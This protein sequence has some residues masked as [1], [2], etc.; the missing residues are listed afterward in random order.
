MKRTALL[1]TAAAVAL[2]T[3]GCSDSGSGGGKHGG[4]FTTIDGN[5]PIDVSAPI[6]PYNQSSNAY[7]GYDAMQLAWQKNSLTDPN[8]FYPGIAKSWQIAEDQSKIT[9]EL[10]PKAKWS[11]GTDVTADDIK[12]SAAVAFTQ[13]S[14]A[15]QVSPGAAGGLGEV[16]VLGSKKVEFDQAPGAKNNTF[17]KNV[18]TLYVLPKSVYSS[19][20]PANFWDQLKTAID[21]NA[22]DAAAQKAAQ[23]AITAL[24]KKLV[25]FG[26]K[27]DISCGPFVL[28]RLN[29]SEALLVKNKYYFNADKIGPDK[30]ISKN[31]S[32]NEQIWNYLIAGKLDMA[33]YT[34]TPTNVVQK[35]LSK[36]GNK[37]IT[38]VSQVVASLAF[39]QS[40]HPF[41]NVHVRRGLAYLID[42]KQVTKVGE[43]ESGAASVTTS[44]LHAKVASSVLGD[45]FA[46]LNKYDVDKA[47]AEQELTQGGL[48]KNGNTWTFNGQPFTFNV[49]VPNGFTDW[50]SGAQSIASQLTD[51]GIAVKVQTSAD[52]ATYLKE[53]AAGKYPVG[54]WLMGLGPG[55]YNAYQRLYGSA[56]GWQLFGGQVVHKPAGQSGNWMGGPETADVAGLGTVNPGQLTY[57]LSQVDPDQQKSIVAKLAQFTNDQLPVIQLWDYVNVQFANTTRFSDFPPDYGDMERLSP[58]VWMQLGYIHKK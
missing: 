2:A 54:F 56:N 52:Y 28:Q 11:D 12:V 23:D 16:K 18:L 17:A 37:K 31:Y 9:V 8:Q 13:A 48:V 24:G 39:N 50:V 6:N 55:N 33:P 14:G 22:T 38:S 21:P 27:K 58:G 57:Q 25:A 35:I 7:T 20:L 34:A 41:D 30:I 44:G 19:Q 10:Q 43:P 46:K 36:S 53:L 29:P 4:T 15:F 5:H 51:A 42:R 47:K 26:P 3:A 32:G 49:Q 45:T 1:A 40:V